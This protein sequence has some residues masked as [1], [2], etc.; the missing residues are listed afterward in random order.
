MLKK[1]ASK[2]DNEDTYSDLVEK[3]LLTLDKMPLFENNGKIVNYIST[4]IRNEYILLSKRMSKCSELLIVDD[5]NSK[6]I[7]GS[8][9]FDLCSNI[10]LIESLNS[11]EDIEKDTIIKLF[12][13]GYKIG[14]L[15]ENNNV[16]RQTIH[17]IKKRAL[18]KL[19]DYYTEGD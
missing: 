18:A 11:L 10:A 6:D 8:S 14:E 12:F 3:I 9:N 15:A 5:P 4:T 19:K 1:Y 13:L 16:T 2:V 17:N 7:I